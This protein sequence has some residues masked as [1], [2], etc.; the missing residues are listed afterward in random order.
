MEPFRKIH[1]IN[2]KRIAIFTAGFGEGHNSAARNIRQALVDKAAGACEADVFDLFDQCY[3][4]ANRL[5]RRIYAFAIKRT[6]L[7]WRWFYRSLDKLTAVQDRLGTFRDVRAA[8]ERLV[9]E[10]G[11][12][13]FASVYPVYN[14]AIAGMDDAIA[15]KIRTVTVI[16]DSITINSVWM[17]AG[18]EHYIVPNDMTADVVRKHGVPAG[19]IHALGFPVQTV[20]CHPETFGPLPDPRDGPRLFFVVNTSDALARRIAEALIGIPWLKITISAGKRPRLEQ[21]LRHLAAASNGRVHVMGWTNE[22]PKLLM[23]HHALIGK[24]GGATTQEAIAARCPMIVNKIVPGQEEGNWDLLRLTGGG[25]LASSPDEI[26]RAVVEMFADDAAKWRRMRENL[27]RIARPDAA[28]RIAEY[29]MRL[30]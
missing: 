2:V 29:L 6:P 11:V 27:D 22:M 3:P 21:R 10:G 20:F 24:C 15:A 7:L 12:N 1:G 28:I 9:V 4:R 16:T 8:M 5:F 13:V 19:Q 25:V 30:A 14:F 18:C 26:K 23:T 17:R